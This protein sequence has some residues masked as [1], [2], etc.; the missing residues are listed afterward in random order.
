MNLLHVATTLT[1]VALIASRIH[2]VATD[3]PR[4]MMQLATSSVIVLGDHSSGSY[5]SQMRRP[6]TDQHT[7]R[8]ITDQSGLATCSLFSST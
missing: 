7:R 1:E 2:I 5:Q 6:I 8:P 4:P 3:M